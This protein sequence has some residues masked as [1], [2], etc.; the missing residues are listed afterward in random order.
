MSDGVVVAGTIM[1]DPVEICKKCLRPKWQKDHLVTEG[2]C[3]ECYPGIC[4]ALYERN[5]AV[6]VLR[7]VLKSQDKATL[8][9]AARI[10]ED[11]SGPTRDC[12]KCNHPGV[13]SKGYVKI[14]YASVADGRPCV[15]SFRNV[16]GGILL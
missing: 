13:V 2:V 8:L 5:I 9:S 1:S 16:V 14:H 11:L 6:A 10:L 15:A 3:M 4:Q 7:S 12:P